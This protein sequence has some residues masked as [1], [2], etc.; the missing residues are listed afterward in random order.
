MGTVVAINEDVAIQQ[1]I[2]DEGILKC[3][4]WLEEELE[5]ERASDFVYT[6]SEFLSIANY[7]TEDYDELLIGLSMVEVQIDDWSTQ[8]QIKIL[9][10]LAQKIG[11]KASFTKMEKTNG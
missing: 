2:E 9:E 1:Q 5:Q 8:S 4:E 10:M 7:S 3:S 11:L 6:I